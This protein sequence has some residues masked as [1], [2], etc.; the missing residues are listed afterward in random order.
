MPTVTDIAELEFDENTLILHIRMIDGAEMNLENTKKHYETIHQ[1][2]GGKKYRVLIDSSK[3]F[4]VDAG[5]F[6]FSSQ[7]DITSR[8]IAVAH[9][10][11]CLANKMMLT[12][13]KITYKPPVPLQ[14]FKT[15]QEAVKWLLDQE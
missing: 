8:R 14:L 3:F 5:S 4:T 15:R 7:P 13:Y 10:D 6:R 11:S 1:L 12:F 9:Y 2:T